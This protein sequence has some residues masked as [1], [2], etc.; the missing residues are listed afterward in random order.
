MDPR[1]QSEGEE[2]PQ[3]SPCSS[4]VCWAQRPTQDAGGFLF[5]LVLWLLCWHL[6][7][8]K[9]FGIPALPLSH[10]RGAMHILTDSNMHCG[11]FTCWKSSLSYNGG[12]LLGK[13]HSK[14]TLRHH[15]QECKWP[16]WRTLED[17][18]QSPR[19]PALN[20]TN[21]THMLMTAVPICSS[22]WNQPRRGSSW[23]ISGI[24]NCSALKPH[25]SCMDACVMP[26]IGK[27]MKIYCKVVVFW[28]WRNRHE[29]QCPVQE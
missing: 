9:G 3:L 25:S 4:S 15:G 26:R 21:L 29:W 19:P 24:R 17:Q 5:F 16:P 22:S 7:F 13:E 6:N 23:H 18:S 20:T 8:S 10:C 27:S 11:S 1:E 14:Q 28:D 12:G 2:E